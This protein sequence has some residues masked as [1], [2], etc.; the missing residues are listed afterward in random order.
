MRCP[1]R[2]LRLQCDPVALDLYHRNFPVH[3]SNLL[4]TIYHEPIFNPQ[5]SI[6]PRK[7]SGTGKNHHQEAFC[8]GG[9]FPC[10]PWISSPFHISAV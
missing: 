10:E 4:K 7:C 3:Y 9:F 8:R 5:F 2:T 6:V 1:M